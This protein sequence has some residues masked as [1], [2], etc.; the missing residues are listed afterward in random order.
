MRR[1]AT[2]YG[3]RLAQRAGDGVHKI[4]VE[5]Q[6]LLVLG[7]AG[8]VGRGLLRELSRRGH[9]CLATARTD[10]ERKDFIQHSRTPQEGSAFVECV[11]LDVD[12]EPAAE[13]FAQEV[14]APFA[15]DHVILSFAQSTPE[16]AMRDLSLEGFDRALRGQ[17]RSQLVAARALLPQLGESG[18]FLMVNGSMALR[19]EAGRGLTHIPAAAA[20]MLQRVL[21][22]EHDRGPRIWSLLLQGAVDVKDLSPEHQLSAERVADAVEFLMGRVDSTNSV[23]GL[24]P[25]RGLRAL[26]LSVEEAADFEELA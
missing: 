22:A 11:V 9:P 13:L 20:L 14:A 6:R 12:D 10:A 4:E 5:P 19:A 15:V 7:G 26:L 24:S 21:A 16:L 8:K 18:L 1:I 2:S 3:H 25:Q 17:L 23:F